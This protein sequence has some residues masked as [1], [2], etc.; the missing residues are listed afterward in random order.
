M[1]VT[2]ALGAA[3]LLV[4]AAFLAALRRDRGHAHQG[5]ACE[6]ESSPTP[7]TRGDPAI[8]VGGDKAIVRYTSLECGA[9]VQSYTIMPGRVAGVWT[10]VGYDSAC[11]YGES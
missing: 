2:L 11:H 8:A 6:E 1:R 4:A 7:Y 3:A 10:V 5:S 9:G